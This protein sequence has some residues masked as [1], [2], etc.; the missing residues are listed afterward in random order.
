MGLLAEWRKEAGEGQEEPT[1]WMTK[2]RHDQWLSK[3]PEDLR[4]VYQFL[5]PTPDTWYGDMLPFR[6]GPA[7][8]GLPRFRPAL[9]Q[10]VRTPLLGFL[11][12]AAAT[13]TGDLTPE[14]LDFL[15]MIPFGVGTLLAPAGSLAVG[16]SRRVSPPSSKP[17]NIKKL[18][19]EDAVR[20]ARDEPHLI[21]SG[22]GT[23]RLY[24]A[25]PSNV[26]S[27]EDL[28]KRRSAYD[29]G[30]EAGAGGAHWFQRTRDNL[31]EVTGGDP[32]ANAW[33]ARAHAMWSGKVSP[34]HELAFALRELNASTA[35]MSGK[36]SRQ[37]QH[38]AHLDA[39]EH[40]DALRYP[41]AEKTG[42]Y[43]KHIEPPPPG[44]N[45]D[46]RNSATGVND[47]RIARKWGYD[48]PYK[49][50][51]SQHDFMHWENA[52]AVHRA[53]ERNV[54]GRSDWTGEEVQAAVW[55]NDKKESILQQIL[56]GRL[57]AAEARAAAEGLTAEERAALLAR[58]RADADAEAFE[59][60]NRTIG[61]Y[62]G[63][64]TAY[65][66]YPSTPGGEVQGHMA[67]LRTANAD[68][69]A[70]YAADPRSMSAIAPGGRDAMYAGTGIP[71]T[72]VKM[73]VRP[74]TPISG[75]STEVAKPLVAFER[76]GRN[77]R[78]PE[79]DRTLLE[80][81][82][83]ARGAVDVL[84]E[85]RVIKTWD[86]GDVG[87]TN[88]VRFDFHRPLSQPEK[89]QL[90]ER[91]K[92]YGL[93]EMVDVGEGVVA[94]NFKGGPIDHKKLAAIQRDIQEVLPG[95]NPVRTYA[96]QVH[97]DLQPLFARGKGSG[98]VTDELLRRVSRNPTMREVLDHNEYLSELARG[99]F[100]RDEAW[101]NILGAPRE[102]FQ[103]LRNIVGEGPGWVSR[104]EDARR[105]GSVS[106][107]SHVPVPVGVKLGA[108]LPAGG[109]ASLPSYVPLPVDGL[110]KMTEEAM[111]RQSRELLEEVLRDRT[112]RR[113]K[114]WLRTN[115]LKEERPRPRIPVDDPIA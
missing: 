56:G 39:I 66:L 25:G 96:E 34:E 15:T 49:L 53:R 85:T 42:E 68:V 60:A 64:H 114:E 24:E 107:P 43:V 81:L 33:M 9:P 5:G 88:A 75:E 115:K 32:V 13:K 50:Q 40:K 69:R 71:G 95:V 78:M 87:E 104:L 94:A 4:A 12:L 74:T 113:Q 21:E 100:E 7:E 55:V 26:K 70:A 10:A 93:P 84:P 29:M 35:G 92:A 108:G 89:A 17:P 16:G 37:W 45:Y 41:L 112:R 22:N 101:G 82:S 102:D 98:A 61:D 77:K 51:P 3:K 36:A 19:L 48:D 109:E 1:P 18:S 6:N 90:S 97:N 8:G 59:R 30:V 52:L 62:F 83:Y 103:N 11:D 44:A 23:G 105:S 86:G 20:T 111:A 110:P 76:R 80:T 28:Q 38:D 91:M 58:V 27:Y 46:P 67:G 47:V 99:R 2:D 65:E 72:G 106:L 73:R 79:A 54:A 63:K 31:R 14:A 57:K